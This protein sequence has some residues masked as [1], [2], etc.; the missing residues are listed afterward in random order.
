MGLFV[1]IK[2]VIEIIFVFVVMGFKRRMVKRN[3]IYRIVLTFL[4]ILIEV[5]LVPFLEIIVLLH[6][7]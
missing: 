2:Y 7:N 4:V 6:D 5:A 1:A 3:N